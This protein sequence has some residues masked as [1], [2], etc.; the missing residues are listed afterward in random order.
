MIGWLPAEFKESGGEDVCAESGTL[1]PYSCDP[2]TSKSH[3]AL[4]GH[5]DLYGSQQ[6]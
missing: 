4:L 5:E 2:L 6:A 3:F 1:A